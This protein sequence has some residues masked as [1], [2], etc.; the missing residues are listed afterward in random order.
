[1][2][3]IGMWLY[4][5]TL[6]SECVVSNNILQNQEAGQIGPRYRPQFA[7]PCSR[8]SS[9]PTSLSI[10]GELVNISS[11]VTAIKQFIPKEDN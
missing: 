2:S 6:I 10:F 11:E 1:M 9:I 8:K 3:T 5:T 4:P 7:D